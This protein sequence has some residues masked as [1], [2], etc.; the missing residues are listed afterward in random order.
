MD[1]RLGC[2]RA[3]SWGRHLACRRTH[4]KPD[5]SP[6]SDGML[7]SRPDKRTLRA[8]RHHRFPSEGTNMSLSS[9]RRQFLTTAASAAAVA[10]TAQL[11]FMSKLPRVSGEEASGSGNVVKL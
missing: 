11:G 6:P 7:S 8:R 5:R 4:G 10:S 1:A 9:S 2:Q 3:E